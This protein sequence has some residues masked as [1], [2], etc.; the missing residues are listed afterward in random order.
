MNRVKKLA[1]LLTVCGMVVLLNA[2][3]AGAKSDPTGS[4]EISIK[5]FAIGVGG[6]KGEG[7]LTF[8]GQEYPFKMKGMQIGSIGKVNVEATGNI[9]HLDDLAEFE[10]VYFQA[11]ASITLKETGKSG[12]FLINRH[13]VTMYLK[14]DSEGFDLTLG[15]GGIK[16]KFDKKHMTK[17]Q[18]EM[19]SKK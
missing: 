10:G 5:E 2:P 13:G 15:R 12:V 6:Q 7:V 18:K 8:Q 17:T 11:K 19:V 3:M 9:Y 16:I 1:R 4:V 14:N